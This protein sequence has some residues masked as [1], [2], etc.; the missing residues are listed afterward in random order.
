MNS[1]TSATQLLHHWLSAGFYILG[2]SSHDR[3]LI[4]AANIYPCLPTFYS[5][6]LEEPLQSLFLIFWE[7][8]HARVTRDEKKVRYFFIMHIFSSVGINKHCS[9]Y[10]FIAGWILYCTVWLSYV[11][12]IDITEFLVPQIMEMW[13]DSSMHA[14]RAS[15]CSEYLLIKTVHRALPHLGLFVAISIA[16]C[17]FTSD[18]GHTRIPFTWKRC[19]YDGWGLQVFP[20]CLAPERHPYL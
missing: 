4:T 13:N 14:V 3:K 15:T 1:N 12:C 20:D 7:Y 16:K 6:P 2:N 8:E 18:C 11:N 5:S 19:R 9:A 17:I 10:C